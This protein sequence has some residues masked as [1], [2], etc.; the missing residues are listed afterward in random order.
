MSDI[1]QDIRARLERACTAPDGELDLAET[2]LLLASLDAPDAKLTDY[3]AHLQEIAGDLAVAAKGVSHVRDLA[4]ALSDVLY[5]GH[6]YEGDRETYEDVQNANLMRVIDRRKGLPVALGILVIHAARSQ[7]WSIA[8]VNF[9]GHFLLRLTHEGEQALIDPFRKARRLTID[10]LEG[11]LTH[12]QGPGAKLRAE[13]MQSVSDRDIL[14]RLQN[15]IKSRALAA[16]DTDRAFEVLENMAL[17]APQDPA[18]I[19]ELAVIETELGNIRSAL[20]RLGTFLD[21]RSGGADHPQ[22]TSLIENLKRRLN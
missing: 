21:S 5:R 3:Q 4:A 17:I 14:L 16:D 15:N 7:G 9:P 1:I 2:A 20:G 19:S 10:N 8:G 11:L 18:V 13:F 12:L 22:V 6:G